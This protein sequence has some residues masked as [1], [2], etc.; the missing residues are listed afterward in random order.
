[1]K[2]MA[3]IRIIPFT[4]LFVA[5]LVSCDLFPD[6][7]PSYPNNYLDDLGENEFYA[8]NIISGIFYKL[9]AD[10]L[11][12]GEHCVIWAERGS[13]I[14]LAQAQDIAD[15]YDT[16]IRPRV[17]GAFSKT[18]FTYTENGITHS[19]GDMLDFAN[20]IA[21][22]D[23]RK[24][25]ILLLDIR[26]GFTNPKTDAYVAGYFYGVDLEPKGR[27]PG[28]DL[29]SNSRDMIYI[30]TYP[31]L[32]MNEEQSYS[33]FAHELQHLI[34]YVTSIQMDRRYGMDTWIDEGLSSQAE[35]L[36]FEGNPEGTAEWFRDDEEGTIARGN[37]FFVWD[38][39]QDKQ[40][41]IL[42]DYA[43]VYLFFRWLYLQANAE[44]QQSI[45]YEIATSS[46]SNY[47]AVTNVAKKINASWSDWAI[48]LRTWL[49]ANYYPK[50]TVYGYKNDAYLQDTI[51]VKPLTVRS[52][53]LYPGEGVYSIINNSFSVSAGTGNIRYAG[54]SANAGTLVTSTPYTGNI[55]LTF[56][57][58]TNNSDTTRYETGSL[59]GV[60]PA[61]SSS[62]AAVEGDKTKKR[63]G[64]Y[65]I[66]ARDLLGR[67]SW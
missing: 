5:L 62:R 63:T 19:F 43:T 42:D 30:D 12:E 13:G 41:A 8:Q 29:Y 37:N 40:L 28:T 35:Y 14:T 39:H 15:E 18:D 22:R 54:L 26:D 48:L 9:S 65:V 50:N 61:V 49:A 55:L 7:R 3:K 38:N 59:T 2:D 27:I 44:L 57:A 47:Q 46:S 53:S 21:G 33:T 16:I 52:I 23:D 24:L 11:W 31:G 51:A 32:T 34:N 67:G 45:L 66:D 4:V 17:V 60:S 36:Y 58:N 10:R 1:M 56:N 20:W 6:N 25:T 64:P